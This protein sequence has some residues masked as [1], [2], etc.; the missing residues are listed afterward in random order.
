MSITADRK[1]PAIGSPHPKNNPQRKQCRGEC[2]QL[3]HGVWDASIDEDRILEMHALSRNPNGYAVAC[4]RDPHRVL[5]LDLDRKNGLDGCARITEIAETIGFELPET[6]RVKTPSGWHIWLSLPPGVHVSNSVGKVG[7]ISAPGV[8]VRSLGGGLVG[9]GSRGPKGTYLLDCAPDTPL[10]PIPS[11][12]LD[13]L[14]VR[15]KPR[16]DSF[17]RGT[18]ISSKRITGLVATVLDAKPGSRNAVLFWSACRMAEAVAEGGLSDNE[19]RELLLTAAERIGLDHS[20]AS[21]SI[22]S[23]FRTSHGRA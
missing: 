19:A 15:D 4:G 11:K 14:A 9:P 3:G 1:Y 7:T 20:E 21:V 18:A 12:L 6:I 22:D 23:A 16:T 17:V 5:G 8:D 13:L 2:G 10:A